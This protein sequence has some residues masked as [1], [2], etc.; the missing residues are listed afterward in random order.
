MLSRFAGS[1]TS[2]SY[3]DG[4]WGA[5]TGV[6]DGNGAGA[7]RPADF[8]GHGNSQS[9]DT[10]CAIVYLGSSSGSTQ[11]AL[12]NRMYV[13]AVTPPPSPPSPPPLPPIGTL[14]ALLHVIPLPAPRLRTRVI[15]GKP[16][17][18]T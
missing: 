1:G 6:V 2:F 11:S 18:P 13:L 9:S 14:S 10:A 3:D 8:W 5:G 7:G 17:G 16:R 12:I 4:L 15:E